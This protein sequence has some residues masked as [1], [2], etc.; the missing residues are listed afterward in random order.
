MNPRISFALLVASPP[1]PLHEFSVRKSRG[2][3]CLNA[4]F[5][6]KIISYWPPS[7]LLKRRLSA[8]IEPVQQWRGAGGEATKKKPL[9]NA[10]EHRGK[11]Y[12]DAI[13]GFP[14]PDGRLTPDPSPRIFLAEKS[15]RGV[16][17]SWIFAENQPVLAPLSI[18]E[19]A[20][21]RSD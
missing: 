19:A 9:S 20:I 6:Q 15:W 14:S 11:K 10:E 3:G 1:T 17:K 16:P 21:E 8:A 7:P 2:E 4:G 13:Q 12:G 5:S 18:V